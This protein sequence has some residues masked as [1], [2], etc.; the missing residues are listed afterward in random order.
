MPIH[1][2]IDAVTNERKEIE[3]TGEEL[4]RYLASEAE[5]NELLA[6]EALIHKKRLEI[7]DRLGIT[8]D[9]AKLLL[10]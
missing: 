8:E 9:E 6:K 2:Y 1:V 4:E 10:S 5:H 3:M 7:L